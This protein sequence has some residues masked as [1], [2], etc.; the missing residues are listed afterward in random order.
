MGGM[1][2]YRGVRIFQCA[3]QGDGTVK[4][5]TAVFDHELDVTECPKLTNNYITVVNIRTR[6]WEITVVSFYLEPDQPI[7]PYLEH[8]KW[9]REEMGLLNILVSCDANAKSTCWEGSI[10]DG[11]GEEVS[12]SFEEMGLQ[13]LNVGGTPTFDN[14]R[15]GKQYTSFADLTACSEGLHGLVEDWKVESGITSSDHNSVF[16]ET[17]LEKSKGTSIRRTTRILNTKKAISQ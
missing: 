14:I 15:G 7:E 13:V 8:L 9:I 11:R 2:D 5:A 10:I 6:A 1:R 16:F 3:D 4:A 12:G 17:N